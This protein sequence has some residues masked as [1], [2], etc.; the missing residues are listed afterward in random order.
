MSV[1]SFIKFH[2]HSLTHSAQSH[3]AREY[4]SLIA[5]RGITLLSSVLLVGRPGPVHRLSAGVQLHL[6]QQQAI[7]N[8]RESGPDLDPQPTQQRHPGARF[9]RQQLSDAAVARLPGARP[10]Q[11]A[12]VVLGALQAGHDCRRRLL[13]AHQPR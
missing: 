1:S 9:E 11:S 4:G 5:V 13:P 12:K 6:A 3:P 7:D 8:V 10:R 2:T